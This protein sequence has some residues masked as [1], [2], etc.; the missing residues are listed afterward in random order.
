MLADALTSVTAIVALLA[1]KYF[2]WVWMDPLMGIVG[3]V[4]VGRWSLGLLR[5]T[6]HTLL[7]RQL[8]EPLLKSVR[9][10]IESDGVSRVTDLHAWEIGPQVRSLILGIAAREPLTPDAYRQRLVF[11]RFQ[12]I[13]IEINRM[14]MAPGDPPAG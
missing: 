7:D 5:Q 6:S 8:G 2:D 12:H 13:T 14:D 9:H 3:S 4:L 1:A 11:A 10:A